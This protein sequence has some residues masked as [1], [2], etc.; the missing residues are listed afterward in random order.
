MVMARDDLRKASTRI[1]N[2]REKQ[3]KM[4]AE[5]HEDCS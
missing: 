2:A 5:I 1:D 3:Q 4:N